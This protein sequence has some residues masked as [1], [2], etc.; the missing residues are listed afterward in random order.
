MSYGS[1][2]RSRHFRD[3]TKKVRPFVIY[4]M[5]LS[6]MAGCGLLPDFSSSSTTSQTS[7]NAENLDPRDLAKPASPDEGFGIDPLD[8][9]RGNS[10]LDPLMSLEPFE[11]NPSGSMGTL[12]FN[13][14]L[15]LRK[16][17]QETEKRIDRLENA[18]LG[19]HRDLEVVA[20]SLQRLI[21]I[22]SDIEVLLKQLEILVAGGPASTSSQ[23]PPPSQPANQPSVSGQNVDAFED[24]PKPTPLPDTQI[25]PAAAMSSLDT[26]G[27]VS[28]KDI[29]FGIHPDK[30]R[31]VLDLTG[32]SP[33]N[34]D[35][36][37]SENLLLVELD[38]AAWKT[39]TSK[40]GISKD[41]LKSYTVQSGRSGSG[42][43]LALQLS[44]SSRILSQSLIPA[45]GGG[46][47]KRLVIDLAKG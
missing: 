47:G 1:R 31:I 32:T 45:A 19:M 10:K 8:P 28:V 38:D 27:S 41:L 3:L 14:D 6:T 18:V 2:W 13:L 24:A 17:P 39:A 25:S 22:E 40:S 44:R 26:S 42:S 21:A 35:L 46:S 7:K 11:G 43:L 9:V 12:G 5:L 20:P 37:P 34:L 23:R 29:R 15:Y 30:V 4:A 16:G 36:D 33:F